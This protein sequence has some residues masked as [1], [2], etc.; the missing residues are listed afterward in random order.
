MAHVSDT[1]DLALQSA[2]PRTAENRSLQKKRTDPI[3]PI[4]PSKTKNYSHAYLLSFDCQSAVRYGDPYSLIEYKFQLRPTSPSDDKDEH[5]DCKPKRLRRIGPKTLHPGLQHTQQDQGAFRTSSP[6]KGW[7]LF[8]RANRLRES[9]I[10]H[11][12]GPVIF[13]TI[14]R[15]LRF[16]GYDVTWVVNITDVDDK[17]ICEESGTWY[18]HESGCL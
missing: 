13:D 4:L 3:I 17:L 11:M 16:S 6:S 18:S 9:H 15:Y 14:K 8:V 1:Q 7:H 5:R 2:H 10:G 12:V